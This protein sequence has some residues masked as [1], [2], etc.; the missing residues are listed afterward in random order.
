MYQHSTLV[1]KNNQIKGLNISMKMYE[2]FR[3]NISL[4]NNNDTKFKFLSAYSNVTLFISHGLAYKRNNQ[5]KEICLISRICL[6]CRLYS[7]S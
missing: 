4:L 7:G 3:H 6:T 2:Q 5:N 1:K